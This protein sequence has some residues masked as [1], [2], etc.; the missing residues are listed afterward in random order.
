[1]N[2]IAQVKFP[3]PV[4]MREF[5]DLVQLRALIMNDVIDFMD[6][7]LIPAECTDKS[8]EQNAFIVVTTVA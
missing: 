7:V 6:G 4:K 5:A 2:P 8:I 1:M 3:N